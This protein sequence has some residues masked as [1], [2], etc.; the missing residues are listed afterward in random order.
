MA[1]YLR[2]KRKNQTIFLNVEK[3]TQSDL[4]LRRQ[5]GVTEDRKER[6]EDDK[7]MERE[8]RE[9]R[10]WKEGRKVGRPP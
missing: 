6:K 5:S 2:V 3:V 4:P 1:M 7:G 8:R 10:L 9:G